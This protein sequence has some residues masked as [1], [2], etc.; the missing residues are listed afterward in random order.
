M[1]NE[2]VNSAKPMLLSEQRGAIRVLSIN[3]T[4]YNLM[5]PAFVEKRKPQFNK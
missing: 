1:E 3:D 4:R 5:S 2:P